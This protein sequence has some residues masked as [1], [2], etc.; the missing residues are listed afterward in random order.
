[1]RPIGLELSIKIHL[2]SLWDVFALALDLFSRYR[3][4]SGVVKVGYVLNLL[5][6]WLLLGF[7]ELSFQF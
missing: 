1:M 4:G 5:D 2:L 6:I 3:K 7:E